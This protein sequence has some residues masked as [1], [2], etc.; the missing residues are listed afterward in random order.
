MHC[1]AETG[2][3]YHVRQ[4]SVAKMIAFWCRKEEEIHD[5]N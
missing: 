3:E 2:M 1:A 4:Q 5:E